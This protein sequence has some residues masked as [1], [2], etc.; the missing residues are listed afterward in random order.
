[1]EPIAGSHDFKIFLEMGKQLR[2]G[3]QE[4]M[5]IYCYIS[6]RA[7]GDGAQGH[8]VSQTTRRRPLGA[9]RWAP[10]TTSTTTQSRTAHARRTRS[11][12]TLCKLAF[13]TPHTARGT[14]QSRGTHAQ[15]RA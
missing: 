2:M 14:R 8:S 7:Y 6:M 5:A 9:G 12:T 15:P 3:Q 10:H 11:L 1:M 13:S 4:Y